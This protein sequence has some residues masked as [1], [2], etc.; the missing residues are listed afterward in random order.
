LFDIKSNILP[1]NVQNGTVPSL[2][3]KC[4]PLNDNLYSNLFAN[5][6]FSTDGSVNAEITIIEEYIVR[7]N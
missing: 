3:A 5:C 7:I 6:G 4:G 2:K 1:P